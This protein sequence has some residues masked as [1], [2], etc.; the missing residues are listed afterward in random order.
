MDE[1]FHIFKFFCAYL[2]GLVERWSLLSR[3]LVL[4]VPNCFLS[5]MSLSCMFHGYEK[6]CFNSSWKSLGF[7]ITV[8]LLYESCISLIRHTSTF[9]L[10]FDA[11]K[12]IFIIKYIYILFIFTIL[13]SSNET[14]KTSTGLAY[15]FLI[16][17]YCQHHCLPSPISPLVLQ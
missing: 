5:H 11:R 14:N 10:S 9:F 13:L 17:Q 2:C 15:Q 16:T 7:Q 4:L 3:G 8:H 6:E 1:N 12:F